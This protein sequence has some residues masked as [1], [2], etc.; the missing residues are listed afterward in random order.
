MSRAKAPAPRRLCT[1]CGHVDEEHQ[2]GTG[3]CSHPG[4]Y[5][6]TVC[7]C[8]AF[9]PAPKKAKATA[10]PVCV[11]GHP[12]GWHGGHPPGVYGVCAQQ[13]C[14]C[15]CFRPAKPE[16][17]K[18]KA[19][20][21]LTVPGVPVAK[22]RPRFGNGRTFTPPSTRT[23][24]EALGWAMRQACPGGPLEGPLVLHVQFSFGMPKSW[25]EKRKIAAYKTAHTGRPDLDNLVKLVKDAGNGILW[26]DDS[27]IWQV[28]ASKVW[29]DEAET[30]ISV[31][32]EEEAR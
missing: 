32:Q 28:G 24:E 26:A 1:L 30:Y 29:A 20:A 14:P 16:A 11:C 2:G 19:G 23:A 27:L 6:D 10:A 31:T 22:G 9:E 25:S 7:A 21:S 18:V 3:E 12:M 15:E 4:S 5:A 17:P 8:P 13:G